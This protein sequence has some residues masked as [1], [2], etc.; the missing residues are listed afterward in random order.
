MFVTPRKESPNYANELNRTF[1]ELCQYAADH[2][3]PALQELVLEMVGHYRRYR[4]GIS[5][6]KDR[7]E[8]Q[9]RR[10][11]ADLRQAFE[12]RKPEKNDTSDWAGISWDELV[13]GK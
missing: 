2:D 11:A 1:K 13:Y 8:S 3:D 9:Y 7:M 4:A 5:D 6:A 12:D 10:R